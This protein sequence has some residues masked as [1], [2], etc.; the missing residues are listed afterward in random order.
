[1]KL[2]KLAFSTHTFTHAYTHVHT[3]H[4]FAHITYLPNRGDSQVV[5]KGGVSACAWM[6]RKVVMVMFTNAQPSAPASV[7]RRQKDHTRT[8]ISCPEAVLLYNK[9]MGGVDRGDQLR[10]YYACRTKSRKFYR[11]IFYFLFDVAITNAHIL[12]KNFCPDNVYN[13]VKEFRLQLARELMGDYS[14]RCR[15]GRRPSQITTLPL[16]HFPMRIPDESHSKNFKGGRCAHCKMSHCRKDTTWFCRECEVWLCHNG[17]MHGNCF[18]Q[19][20]KGREL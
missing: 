4:M 11:Y 1:M 17:D 10:G 18:L 7:L 6:D 8:P 15:A 14:S 12:Q 9:Y 20:H 3:I 19:W 16:R 5:Q 2:I 13:N